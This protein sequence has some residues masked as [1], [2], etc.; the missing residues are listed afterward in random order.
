MIWSMSNFSGTLAA[1]LNKEQ[2]AAVGNIVNATSFPLPYLL[3]GPAGKK[4]S[5]NFML[6]ALYLFQSW[7]TRTDK[8]PHKCS[9]WVEQT[10]T[11]AFFNNK[12][13]LIANST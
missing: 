11:N 8:D 6:I 3:F 9:T 12:S 10:A 2:K 5:P 1:K 7:K 4:T 13:P